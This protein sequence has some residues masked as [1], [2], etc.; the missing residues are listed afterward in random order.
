MSVSTDK[1]LI[2]Y[3]NANLFVEVAAESNRSSSQQNTTWLNVV[4]M[5]R[6]TDFRGQVTMFRQ[7][8][9]GPLAIFS[10][11]LK[12]CPKKRLVSQKQIPPTNKISAS[13]LK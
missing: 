9:G 11:F 3:F 6:Q 2:V 8:S 1:H 5:S 12:K 7:T 4:E 10:Y 13:A